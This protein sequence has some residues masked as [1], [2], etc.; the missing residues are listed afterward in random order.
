MT[1]AT[2]TLSIVSLSTILLFV[3]WLL[4]R[5]PDSSIEMIL[6]NQRFKIGTGNVESYFFN[7]FLIR[8]MLIF[9]VFLPFAL[10]IHTILCSADKEDFLR[11]KLPK[12]SFIFGIMLFIF[13][14]GALI[15]QWSLL[16]I[17]IIIP[18]LF[19]FVI[20]GILR[21]KS[22]KSILFLSLDAILALIFLVSI[23]G[24][25]V[26]RPAPI[27]PPLNNCDMCI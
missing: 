9:L 1:K 17:A 24:S 25:M 22:F 19:L 21:K 2:K 26:Q 23:F 5:L 7:L 13:F 6:R 27:G 3:A 20:P 12:D 11:N 14:V 10:L 15:Q 4:A 18:P 8:G 16:P